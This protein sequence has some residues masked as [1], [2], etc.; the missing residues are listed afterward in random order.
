MGRFVFLKSLLF[1]TSVIEY[2]L[3]LYALQGFILVYSI[4]AQSTFADL[5]DLKNQICRV[6]DRDDVSYFHT[7]SL[8]PIPR[9]SGFPAS[10]PNPYFYH[11]PPLRPMQRITSAFLIQRTTT[12]RDCDLR[13]S[14]CYN[15]LYHNIPR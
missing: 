1:L 2:P 11:F 12:W 3:T 8:S 6:K 14:I 9:L 4:I 15:I 7:L 13:R 5:E 10:F